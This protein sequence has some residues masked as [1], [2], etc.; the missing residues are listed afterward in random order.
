MEKHP[1]EILHDW[2][3][4]FEHKFPQSRLRMVNS[5]EGDSAIQ[6]TIYLHLIEMEHY[7]Y[8]LL[9]FEQP[10]DVDNVYGFEL[11]VFRDDV[12]LGKIENGQDFKRALD[13]ILAEERTKRI[14]D[15]VTTI[16]SVS[17]STFQVR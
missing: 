12:S 8:R 6:V 16:S 17:G 13:R 5:S 4:E 2:I 11:F 10:I 1:T 14:I 3:Q 7:N 15:Q 9:Q